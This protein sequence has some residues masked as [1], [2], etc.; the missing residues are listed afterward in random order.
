MMTKEAILTKFCRGI[1][2][3]GI[4]WNQLNLKL[5][6]IFSSDQDAYNDKCQ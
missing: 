4:S 5:F 6:T 1:S 3:E 2:I